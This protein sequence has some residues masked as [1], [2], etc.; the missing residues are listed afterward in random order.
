MT[1]PD[2]IR[3]DPYA[4]TY[5]RTVS[6]RLRPFVRLIPKSFWVEFK[7]TLT[8][9]TESATR[10]FHEHIE[11]GED[12]I[13]NSGPSSEKAYLPAFIAQQIEDPRLRELLEIRRF[14]QA[15]EDLCHAVCRGDYDHK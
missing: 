3:K 12:S 8:L 10:N 1:K 5:S 14:A 2:Q 13:L 4:E 11:A 9:F 15:L 6:N 7:L